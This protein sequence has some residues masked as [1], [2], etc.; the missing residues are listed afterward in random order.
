MS[1][2]SPIFSFAVALGHY[3][4]LL[5]SGRYSGNAAEAVSETSGRAVAYID[6]V[7]ARLAGVKPAA[8]H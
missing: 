5:Q 7:Q 8:Q 6:R 3:L 1:N 2:D 4:D